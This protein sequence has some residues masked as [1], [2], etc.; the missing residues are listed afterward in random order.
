M[1]QRILRKCYQA[2]F[3]A[4]IDSSDLDPPISSS[5]SKIPANIQ[6]PDPQQ[7]V[8]SSPSS[9]LR[10]S[11]SNGNSEPQS[12]KPVMPSLNVSPVQSNGQALDHD[13]D[14]YDTP[15]TNSALA[16]EHDEKQSIAG[17]LSQNPTRS[18]HP[19]IQPPPPPWL[20][21]DALNEPLKPKDRQRK[22]IGLHVQ[23]PLSVQSQ[24]TTP[25]T[26]SSENTSSAVGF[27]I[28]QSP[29]ALTPKP[30]LYS[31]ALSNVV[32][33][34]SAK[35]RISFSDYL[36]RKGSSNNANHTA[37]T[38]A[39]FATSSPVTPGSGS[40]PTS[41]LNP[42]V[43]PPTSDGDGIDP[44]VPKLH[45]LDVRKD[46]GVSSAEVLKAG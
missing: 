43:A 4:E 31:P 15:D 36:S 23:L 38:S 40:G 17:P 29:A 5:K 25:S 46:E 44:P 3:R 19:P 30:P 24:P 42:A 7:A 11:M 10:H 9:P 32:G 1:S 2:R 21:K 13:A 33:H 14:M 35:K 6:P 12:P 18:T 22:A 39:G 45:P 37:S 20:E 16:S 27:A 28:T 34:S 8:S 41:Q 26:P